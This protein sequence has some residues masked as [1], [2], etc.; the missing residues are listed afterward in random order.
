VAV[1]A[2]KSLLA[3][4]FEPAQS[5]P[6]EEYEMNFRNMMKERVL[7]MA[8]PE[9]EA[10]VKRLASEM[11]RQ[12][13]TRN[14][15]ETPFLT[16]RIHAAMVSL[17]RV[18]RTESELM[19]PD[20]P[21]EAYERWEKATES[22]QKATEE[23]EKTLD[24]ADKTLAAPVEAAEHSAPDS[25]A[26]VLEGEQHRDSASDGNCT[27]P[28]DDTVPDFDELLADHPELVTT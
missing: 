12:I 13:K 16:V 24:R 28:L 27:P 9:N 26:E 4:A 1:V 8:G 10:S 2:S 20:A 7:A 17:V 3:C 21:D 15:K 5:G 22:L 18:L 11:R 19:S 25:T 14:L 6:N 23:F